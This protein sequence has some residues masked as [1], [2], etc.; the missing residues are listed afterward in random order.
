MALFI[1]SNYI[2]LNYIL[3]WSD[4]QT[5]FSWSLKCPA[6]LWLFDRPL[7]QGGSFLGYK[8]EMVAGDAGGF[9]LGT[10]SA[11]CLVFF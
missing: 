8:G 4:S 3:S 10:H 1:N 6:Q 5:N 2:L 7:S 9:P 11:H